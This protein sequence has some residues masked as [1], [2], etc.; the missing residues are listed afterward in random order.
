ML[1]L[2]HRREFHLPVGHQ[3]SQG[4]PENMRRKARFGFGGRAICMAGDG[5]SH[6]WISGNDH[7][8][9]VAQV[10]IPEP[11]EAAQVTRPFRQVPPVKIRAR[12][13]PVEKIRDQGRQT[14]L[15]TLVGLS[16]FEGRMHAL[17]QQDYDV[18]G[19]DGGIPALWDGTVMKKIGGGQ[20]KLFSGYL[21]Q[22]E[23]HLYCG[24]SS[25]AGSS[26]IN[27]GPTLYKV[28]QYQAVLRL[29]EDTDPSWT[30]ADDWTAL[31]F[32]PGHVCWLI[33]K[34]VGEVWYGSRYSPSGLEDRWNGA[35][36]YHTDRRE[37]WL[38]PYTWPG[39]EKRDTIVLRDFHE[40][41]RCGGLAYDE[42]R[43]RLY[44]HEQWP[45]T[46]SPEEGYAGEKPKIH[47]Y[48][49]G[50][51]EPAPEPE[52]TRELIEIRIGDRRWSG[53]VVEDGSKR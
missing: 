6:L 12:V 26:S 22:H 40:S 27:H 33:S 30:N 36:G 5:S 21:A 39:L 18:D 8:D 2:E 1:K 32:L 14:I 4:V 7:A 43:R 9:L 47:V 48:S 28:N 51:D 17:W 16:V 15:D 34:A 45:P 52:P 20:L 35:K 44:V 24:R 42:D 49:V 13:A 25:G 31:V 29:L 50:N 3:P 23:G 53:E 41:A 19:R 38:M 11:D 46:T 10:T 37:V